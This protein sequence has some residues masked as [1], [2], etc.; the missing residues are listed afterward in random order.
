MLYLPTYGGAAV[1]CIE[2]KT[3]HKKYIGSSENLKNRVCSHFSRLKK[4]NH[5]IEELQKDYNAGDVFEVYE[6]YR[7]DKS[8]YD[9]QIED[10]RA[11]EYKTIIE[12]DS[13][14]SGYNRSNYKPYK[15]ILAENK[16]GSAR[17]I[18]KLFSFCGAPAPSTSDILEILKQ[19]KHNF[20]KRFSYSK[21][22]SV[23]NEI[24]EIAPLF[25]YTF[26]FSFEKIE[27]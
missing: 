23:L 11:V 15:M 10:I 21:A 16:E 2:N 3:K 22:K 17:E 7:S 19:S 18:K 6:V 20:V 25:G 27:K 13:L 12:T 26:K 24:K 4:G 9:E 1:Y 5:D 14:N 8:T